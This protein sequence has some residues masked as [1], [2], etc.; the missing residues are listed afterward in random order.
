MGACDD[1]IL[2]RETESCKYIGDFPEKTCPS[3]ADYERD[4]LSPLN[5]SGHEHW[6]RAENVRGPRASRLT[7]QDDFCC[8]D[9]THV[10]DD[11]PP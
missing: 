7:D 6:C 11:P 10:S 4:Y 5:C 3:A 1:G 8:Y 9:Y 2:R